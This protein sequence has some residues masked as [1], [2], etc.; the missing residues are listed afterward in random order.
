M[1]L[2]DTLKE[3]TNDARKCRI[4]RLLATVDSEDALTLGQALTNPFVK[5]VTLT[6][7]LRKE[8]GHDAVTDHSVSDWRRKHST[9]MEV[10]GL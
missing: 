3:V 10:T 4:E 1:A 2:Q 9:S 8:Y 5:P 7:A 6:K